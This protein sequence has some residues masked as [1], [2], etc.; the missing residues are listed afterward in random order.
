MAEERAQTPGNT[1]IPLA[2]QP[3]L[4]E[5]FG[6]SSNLVARL[7]HFRAIEPP[8][9][10]DFIESPDIFAQIIRGGRGTGKT[11]LLYCRARCLHRQ[12]NKH[13]IRSVPPNGF[14][15]N[16]NSI[17]IEKECFILFSKIETWREAWQLIIGTIFAFEIKRQISK[18]KSS[19]DLSE[20][21]QI[22]K[23]HVDDDLM[24]D[25]ITC[26]FNWSKNPHDGCIENLIDVILRHRQSATTMRT[27]YANKVKPVFGERAALPAAQYWVIFV[28]RIDEALAEQ[29]GSALLGDQIESIYIDKKN[30][31]HSNVKALAQEVWKCS[32]AGYAIAAHSIKS[33]TSGHLIALGTIREEAYQT[34]LK[35]IGLPENKISTFLLHL[36]N[37]EQ[38]TRS[39]FNLNVSMMRPLD[40]CTLLEKQN[41]DDRDTDADIKLF[42]YKCLYDRAVFGFN[43]SPYSY[44]YRHTFGTP[45]GLMTLGQAVSG[46][47]LVERKDAKGFN[48]RPPTQVIDTVNKTAVLV[49]E[50]YRDNIFPPWDHDYD[51]G[52]GALLSNIMSRDDALRLE[53]NLGLDKSR[54]KLTLVE[55]LYE[56]GLIGVPTRSADSKWI[57]TFRTLED[58]SSFGAAALP[59]D[60]KYILLHP[61]LSAYRCYKLPLAVKKPFYN[62]WIVVSPGSSCPEELIDPVVK[63][64]FFRGDHSSYINAHSIDNLKNNRAIFDFADSVGSSFLAVLGVA[65]QFYGGGHLDSEKLVDVATRLSRLGYIPERL[66]KAEAGP[67]KLH[68]GLTKQ[69]TK[70]S[71]EE[72]IGEICD[73]VRHGTASND[74]ATV[75]S[76]K[77]MLNGHGLSIHSLHPTKGNTFCL[78]CS[79]S[80]SPRPSSFASFRPIGKEEIL[81]EGLSI[82]A[83]LDAL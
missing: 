82:D 38:T 6:T 72:W 14:F 11:T 33:Q 70:K 15:L 55:Y 67:G 54:K 29:N 80:A 1:G 32:Q 66:G 56:N 36:V 24:R 52:I 50:E 37:D 41:P 9:E 51:A 59:P 39:I 74:S 2:W 61:A 4:I 60:F 73:Y 77:R 27:I 7:D 17:F 21:Y 63:F 22:F 16:A 5:A 48:W 71:A 34:F 19:L 45:R 31:T 26:I 43:E 81:I 3:D 62:P 25:L 68:P 42:G 20:W 57:Q 8:S 30:I 49:F 44:L 58:D 18:R 75:A 12:N 64:S 65:H 23:C 78:C 10:A 47:R 83:Y 13:F 53:K 69:E 46:V 35:G 28:D 40:H 76:A 79:S